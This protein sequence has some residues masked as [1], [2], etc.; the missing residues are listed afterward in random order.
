MTNTLDPFVS[1]HTANEMGYD[2]LPLFQFVAAGEH[3]RGTFFSVGMYMHGF[4]LFSKP[5]L[6]C[7]QTMFRHEA[8]LPGRGPMRSCTPRRFSDC[9]L[10]RL[11]LAGSSRFFPMF[12]QQLF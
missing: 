3:A 2:K 7:N 11:V 8:V 6:I 1:E 5:S 9:A 4:G 12:L 10:V